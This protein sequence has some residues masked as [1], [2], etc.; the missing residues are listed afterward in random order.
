MT[1][2]EQPAHPRLSIQIDRVINSL[3]ALSLL[4]DT[5][6]NP[7]TL[8]EAQCF[9]MLELFDLIK[10][11]LEGVAD[12][13]SD[14]ETSLHRLNE[15]YSDFPK[16]GSDNIDPSFRG[17]TGDLPPVADHLVYPKVYPATPDA[18]AADARRA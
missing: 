2:R 12:R 8:T 15:Y 9:G 18:E 3:D 5:Y 1:Q 13:A 4:F 17:W 16:E 7:R 11:K 6:N 14:M 10:L